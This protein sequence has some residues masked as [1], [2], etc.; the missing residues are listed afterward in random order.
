MF[1][2]YSKS[3]ENKQIYGKSLL[4]AGC[5]DGDFVSESRITRSDNKDPT[6]NSA[7]SSTRIKNSYF[8]WECTPVELKYSESSTTIIKQEIAIRS[9][10]T[11]WLYR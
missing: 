6:I 8:D 5:L 1:R 9:L 7:D 10:K 2:D 4:S 11:P 3:I